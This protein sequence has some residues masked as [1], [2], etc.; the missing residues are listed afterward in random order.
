M[1][2]NV[3]IDDA[4]ALRAIEQH[5]ITPYPGTTSVTPETLLILD[6]VV[7]KG[8][9]D[10]A[11]EAQSREELSGEELARIATRLRQA[12]EAMLE[13]MGPI[14]GEYSSR[15]ETEIQ[16]V[17][18]FEGRS[19]NEQDRVDIDIVFSIARD[20]MRALGWSEDVIADYTALQYGIRLAA[21]L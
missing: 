9:N 17:G 16:P 1:A 6:Q 2:E 15:A 7:G 19:F 4:A 8:L 10:L 5:A 20:S 11:I 21:G 14:L 12:G 18:N 13:L 3:Q